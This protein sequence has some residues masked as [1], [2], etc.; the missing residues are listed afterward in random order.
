[1]PLDLSPFADRHPATLQVLK[2][3]DVDGLPPGAPRELGRSCTALAMQHVA[4]LPDGPEL[5]I[6]LRALLDART[7][8][9]RAAIEAE[10]GRA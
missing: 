5:T 6:G 4:A 7:A 8:F 2:W 9:T 10:E 1:M 3:F